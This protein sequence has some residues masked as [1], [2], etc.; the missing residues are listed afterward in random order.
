MGTGGSWRRV[1]DLR[2]EPGAPW[3]GLGNGH[4]SSQLTSIASKLCS[5]LLLH[6]RLLLGAVVHKE[7]VVLFSPLSLAE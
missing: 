4:Q 6:F 3:V 7:V 2:P 1:K 5:V